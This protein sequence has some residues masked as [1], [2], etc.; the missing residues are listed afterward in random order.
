MSRRDY[1]VADLY[2]ERERDFYGSGRRGTR[3]YVDFEE[4]VRTTRGPD[5]LRED[6]GRSA[7]AGPLVVRGQAHAAD[8]RTEV[9]VESRYARS[10]RGSPPRPRTREIE[11]EEIII[12]EDR[13]PAR[14]REHSVDF[15]AR[16]S[17]PDLRSRPRD[18]EEIDIEIRRDSDARSVRTVRPREVEREEIDIDIRR[19]DDDTRSVRSRRPREAEKEEIDIDIRHGD[20][21][22]VRSSRPRDVERDEVTIRRSETARPAPRGESEEITI[23]RGEG[24][25]PPPSLRPRDVERTEIDIKEDRRGGRS[26]RDVES[27]EIDITRESRGRGYSPTRE[28][29]TIREQSR[30]PPP[31][32]RSM[33]APNL[34]RRETEE[35]VIRRRRPPSPSPSPSPS[36]PPPP[37]RES[38]QEIIIRRTEQRSPTPPPPPPPEPEPLPPPPVLAPITRPP[39]Y[40][41]IH[42]EII[43][44]HRH[45]D[46]GKLD[47]RAF[48]LHHVA[49]KNQ[50]SSVYV[51]QPRHRC[52]SQRLLHL[53]LPHHKRPSNLSRSI[54]VEGMFTR[55]NTQSKSNI[56]KWLQRPR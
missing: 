23:R 19:R 18:K 5:F 42:Q 50:V 46:H 43:T 14:R 26:R 35:F 4:D 13:G 17:V 16:R 6:Y 32:E 21:R 8:R 12:R 25:R 44:H 27:E 53:H 39:I 30:G 29:I 45:I 34:V 3:E 40:Q 36:P 1:P 38:R 2:E 31:R 47:T 7:A 51:R 55:D 33:P 37:M 54:F 28:R 48:L 11:K 15:S 52:A 24:T 20:A 41:E 10:A 22:S 9:D 49:N 56:V